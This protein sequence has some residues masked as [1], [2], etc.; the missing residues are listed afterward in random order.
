MSSLHART[1]SGQ[2]IF[3]P[4]DSGPGN[5]WFVSSVVGTVG[6]S[7]KDWEHAVATIDAGIN[8]ASAGDRVIVAPNHAE[9][10]A[11]ANGFDLDV[12]GVEVCGI[13]RGRLMPT[14]TFTTA[15]GADVKIAGI[16]S[17]I[18][19]LRFLGGFDALTGPI[20]VSGVADAY[21]IDCEY[22]DV[23]GEAT[24]II[25]ATNNSDRLL[26]DGFRC[27]G[28][29]GAGGN[30]AIALDGCDDVIVRNFDIYGN[31]ALGA[32][33]FRT[34]L[35]ARVWIHDGH[36]T[37]AHA[38]DLC[39]K[40]LITGSTGHIGPNLYLET[41]DDAE[42]ITEAITGATFSLFDPIYVNNAVAEKAMLIDWTAATQA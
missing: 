27:M 25:H 7:G 6:N 3:Y 8:L 4:G 23:T 21:I 14:I 10:V 33:E 17:G 40:D 39:I 35:S 12:A 22:R 26:I 30:T 42:T 1:A 28:A 9:S 2:T 36:I 11:A 5:E 19:N 31:F 13:R 34:T 29:A 38:N 37:T 15:V 16:G 24:D 41:A 18:R 32:I 20:E